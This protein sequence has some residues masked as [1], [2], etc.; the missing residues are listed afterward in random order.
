M[1]K[2]ALIITVL[3]EEKNIVSLLKSIVSQTLKPSELIIV[4]GGSTDTTVKKITNY[5]AEYKSKKETQN[6]IKLIIKTKKGNRSVGRNYAVSL[7]TT[8]LIAITD[9]GCI[10]DTQWLEEL[11][12]KYLQT[13]SPV[14]AGYY[15]AHYTTSFQEAVV[16]YVLVM[17]DMVAEDSFLP[18]TRS[19]LIKKQ[20][21]ESLSGFDETLSDNEDY[22]F[23][24][25][26]EAKK[27]KISFAKQAVAHWIPRKNI[28]Q[29]YTMIFR[30]ARGDMYAKIIRPKV[31][32]I[33]ARYI[34]F[35]FLLF[36]SLFLQVFAEFLIFASICLVLYSLWA[37]SK[38]KK[39]VP[40]GYWYLPVLQITSDV[41]V[42][43][44][45]TIGFLK[46]FL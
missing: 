35:I 44:G 18:A 24:K 29:F 39:Y 13:S 26:I 15:D 25:K 28:S 45:S 31:V 12:K 32:L 37:I 7:A 14:I 10:L 36:L 5:F 21:F 16:P 9:A 40:N 22:V 19:M 23:A 38:N 27:I 41:A 33:F 2:V 17:P 4:D 43:H 1:N 46:K 30:F 20:V 11:V 34:V 8:P 6:K 42:L 3:N